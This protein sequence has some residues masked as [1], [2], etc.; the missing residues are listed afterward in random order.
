MAQRLMIARAL[1]HEPELLFLDEPTTGL[2][3]QARLFVWDRIRDL[4]AR[5]LTVLLTTHDMDEAESLCRRVAI[6]DHGKILALDTPAALRTL[7]PGAS[8]L[9]LGV[10]FPEG[11]EEAALD[12]L[13]RSLA[14]LPGVDGVDR[15][16]RPAAGAG[17]MAPGAGP[18]AAMA[19]GPSPADAADAS[20]RLPL[21]R[22]YSERADAL[23]VPVLQTVAVAG[24]EVRDLHVARASLEDVF[25]HLTG[26]A[27]R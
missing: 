5:G 14:S 21:L 4:N 24:A 15:V 23:I 13:I 18:W 10:A 2:D 1:M 9:E 27:L 16:E 6:M 20:D 7:V 25:I 8:A 26:K 3:P 17:A 11:T 22:L 19:S 12:D